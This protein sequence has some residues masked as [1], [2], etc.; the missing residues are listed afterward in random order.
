MMGGVGC[1]VLIGRSG[2]LIMFGEWVGVLVG[3]C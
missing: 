2:C 1:I 3:G